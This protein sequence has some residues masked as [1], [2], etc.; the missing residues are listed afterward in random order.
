MRPGA[1]WGIRLT[2]ETMPK[3][4]YCILSTARAGST[5][6]AR[7]LDAAEN[8][9]CHSEPMPNL[10][11]E[12]RLAL[13]GYLTEQQKTQIV[14]EVLKTRFQDGVEEYGIYGE[15]NVTFAHN[16]CLYR[17]TPTNG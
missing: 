17:Y 14:A 6:L 8:G 5:A 3:G 11:R 1:C 2:S 12:T 15:K 9:H 4:S 16:G 13:D 7:L 10:N